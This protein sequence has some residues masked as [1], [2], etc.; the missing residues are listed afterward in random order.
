MFRKNTSK[1]NY[2]ILHTPTH[3]AGIPARSSDATAPSAANSLVMNAI[4]QPII[5]SKC[6]STSH[7][8]SPF[9]VPRKKLDLNLPFC[10]Q[11]VVLN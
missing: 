11:R 10:L 8:D 3:T 1:L 6:T 9:A 4:S 2:V 5:Q 7:A